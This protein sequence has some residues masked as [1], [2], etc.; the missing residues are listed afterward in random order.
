MNRKDV[1]I[2][3]Q[4]QRKKKKKII[5]KRNFVELMNRRDIE[6]LFKE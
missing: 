1:E 3:F 2:L 6:I 4:K 5:D